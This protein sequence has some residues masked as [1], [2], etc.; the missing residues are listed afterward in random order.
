MKSVLKLVVTIG[1]LAWP[2]LS[3]GDVLSSSELGFTS[4]NTVQVSVPPEKA[5]RR[6]MD[7]V[8][9]WWDAAH[10]FGG[11]ASK[12]RMADKVGGCFCEGL[13]AGGEV[14]HMEIMY[15]Q[16]GKMLRMSGGLGPLQ[17]VAVI[18]IMTWD[19][20][21]TDSGTSIGLTYTVGG[22]TKNGLTDLATPVD[23]VLK[24]QLNR[25]QRFL[26]TGSPVE[27]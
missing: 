2:G 25:L 16:P 18:G 21:A 7:R 19:F 9:Q 17:S 6:M 14:R 3:K 27:P 10:T 5:Y 8:D 11:D 12:L 26:D 4:N 1:M 13:P 24:D 20:V 23:H 22:Y 15:V